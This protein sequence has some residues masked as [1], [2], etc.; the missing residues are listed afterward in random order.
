MLAG[1]IDQ[2]SLLR[3]PL[4][5]INAQLVVNVLR[6]FLSKTLEESFSDGLRNMYALCK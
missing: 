2:S 5:K 1:P 4:L 3:L 6:W